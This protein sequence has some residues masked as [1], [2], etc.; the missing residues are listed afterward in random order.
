MKV[1]DAKK[2]TGSL[3]RTSKMPGMSYSLPAW[4]CKTGSKLSKIPGSVCFNCYAMKNNYIRYP[5]IK[6]AQ[7]DRLKKIKRAQWV[8]AMASQIKNQEFFRWHDAGDVQDL[9]HLKKIFR[10]CELTPDVKHWMP[11]REA[12]ISEHLN[13]K[14]KNLIIRFSATMVDQSSKK[15]PKAW[16]NTSTVSSNLN[17]TYYSEGHLC[18]APKQGNACKDCR[19]CWDG[20][21]RNI[22]YGKH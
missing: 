9:D 6:A 13:E 1:K 5:A 21:I 22:V 18:P 19:A 8:V 10:V 7:Y 4:E 11:T 20:R 12:W 15:L 16:R 17:K 2:I 3:T 14:P